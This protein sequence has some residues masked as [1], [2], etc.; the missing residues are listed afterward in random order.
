MSDLWNGLSPEEKDV[1]RDPY[2]FALAGLPNLALTQSGLDPEDIDNDEDEADLY[3]FQHLDSRVPVPKVHQLSEAEKAKYQP[4]FDRLVNVEKLHL[5][6]G[7]PDP[8]QS[9]ATLQAK[10]LAELRKAH[11]DVSSFPLSIYLS[12]FPFPAT[13]Y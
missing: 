3:G 13:A 5:C 6:H 9:I 8:T 7:R 1:F 11:H 2:F 10:S 4:L 12:P